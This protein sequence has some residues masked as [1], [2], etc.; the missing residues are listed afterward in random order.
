MAKFNRSD[1][2]RGRPSSNTDDKTGNV[3]VT[4]VLA[5]FTGNITKSVTLVGTKVSTAYKTFI[6]ELTKVET[7]KQKVA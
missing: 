5:G 3:R 4:F 2:E 6:S 1:S 7:P